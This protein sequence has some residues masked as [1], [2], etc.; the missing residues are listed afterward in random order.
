LNILNNGKITTKFAMAEFIILVFQISIFLT[1]D[2]WASKIVCEAGINEICGGTNRPDYV[3]G[4]SKADKE[5]TLFQAIPE[6][7]FYRE[8]QVMILLI[9]IL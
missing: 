2:V 3:L 6:A 4:T 5:T 7:I 9:K 8:G 1:S